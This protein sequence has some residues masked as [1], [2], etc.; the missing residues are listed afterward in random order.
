ML[1]KGRV[2]LSFVSFSGYS[3]DSFHWIVDYRVSKVNNEKPS[4]CRDDDKQFMS[5]PPL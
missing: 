4:L 2:L 5:G 3:V 1:Y